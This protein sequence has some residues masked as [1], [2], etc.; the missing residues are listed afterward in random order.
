[1]YRNFQET[2]IGLMVVHWIGN[3]MVVSSNLG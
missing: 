3:Y 1:M 2:R